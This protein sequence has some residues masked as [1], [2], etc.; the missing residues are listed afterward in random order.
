[1]TL[2]ARLLAASTCPKDVCGHRRALSGGQRMIPSADYHPG[3]DGGTLGINAGVA[4]R[5]RLRRIN[6]RLDRI[7]TAFRRRAA[8]PRGAGPRSKWRS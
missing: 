2:S 7:E 3:E 8:L 6:A 1:M 4:I 5:A